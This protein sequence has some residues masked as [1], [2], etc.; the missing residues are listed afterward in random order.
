MS[1]DLKQRLAT[2][3][4]GWVLPEEV[5]PPGKER[6]ICPEME[7]PRKRIT[8]RPVDLTGALP[9]DFKQRLAETIA[10]CLPRAEAARA[11]DTTR[12]AELMPPVCG[13]DGDTLLSLLL[14]SPATSAEAV[15]FIA[16][17]RREALTRMNMPLPPLGELAGGWVYAT[18][19]NTDVCGAATAP[20]N[21]FLDDYDIPGWDTWFAHQDAGE[22]GGIV[23]GWVPPALLALADEG[24]YVIP[25][26][27]AW[28][29]EEAD[30]RRLIAS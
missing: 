23:Y 16:T 2:L 4:A 5:A 7:L 8:V 18:D 25:V 17:R 6:I 20:S 19:F 9:R 26:S 13:H 28:W 15:D 12:T 22:G 1:S 29:L 11:G 27:S 3:F 21:G 24:F 10:W 14:R 30:L